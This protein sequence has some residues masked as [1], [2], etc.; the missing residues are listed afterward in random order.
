[1]TNKNHMIDLI[2]LIYSLI[3]VGLHSVYLMSDGIRRIFPHGYLSVEFF[4]IVSGYLMANS[5]FNKDIAVDVYM[6]KKYKRLLPYIIFAWLLGALVIF[7]AHPEWELILHIKNWIKSIWHV[8]MLDLAGFNGYQIIG[9]FWYLSA[10]FLTMPMLYYFIKKNN[11]YVYGGDFLVAIFIYGWFMNK[12][13]LIINAGGK[14]YQITAL[15]RAIAGMS[16]GCFCY[17]AA[18]KLSQIKFTDLSRVIL[19]IIE[20]LGYIASFIIM[21]RPW[22]GKGD[23]VTFF[24]ILAWAV[25]IPITFAQ[26]S[27]SVLL[28]KKR[29]WKTMEYISM[30]STALYLCHGRM[31]SFVVVTFPQL[32]TFEERVIPYYVISIV[33]S[34]ICVL[35]VKEYNKFSNEYKSKFIKK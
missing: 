32:V 17:R 4:F 10:M 20:C 1:M 2:K 5:A 11:F 8:L 14:F 31:Q 29:Y 3:I 7:L 18:Y 34:I 6:L 25:S 24:I 33:V 26:T 27:F 22:T 9:A 28:I 15:F 13:G 23:T 21:C 12:Y 30:F 16:L 35:F 19:T